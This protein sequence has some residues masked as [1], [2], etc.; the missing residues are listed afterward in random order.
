M[1]SAETTFLIAATHKTEFF[2]FVLNQPHSESR[3]INRSGDFLENVRERAYVVFMTVS[4]DNP[5]DVPILP[6][7][8]FQVRYDDIHPGHGLVREH[9]PCVNDEGIFAESYDHHVQTDFSQSPQW[10]HSQFWCQIISH[11]DL[12]GYIQNYGVCLLQGQRSS[13]RRRLRNS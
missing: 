4:E 3:C 7:H 11:R 2:K 13:L 1:L 8:D 5:Q 9:Q 10:K 12:V 6:D